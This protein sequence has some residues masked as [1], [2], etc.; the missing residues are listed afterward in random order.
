MATITASFGGR[1]KGSSSIAAYS[2]I[3]QL[4]EFLSCASGCRDSFFVDG[5]PHGLA[6]I[7]QQQ[8]Q[9]MLLRFTRTLP[10][11]RISQP[12]ASLLHSTPFRMSQQSIESM[13]NLTVSAPASQR[14]RRE[15][16][17]PIHRGMTKLDRDAF[18]A[19]VKCLAVRVDEK[20][21]GAL[22][23]NKVVQRYVGKT[24]MIVLVDTDFPSVL[25]TCSQILSMS[26]KRAIEPDPN[27]STNKLLLLDVENEGMSPASLKL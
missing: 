17:P 14:S 10:P 3:S 15:V 26:R 25:W 27:T 2:F 5:I 1:G 13:R 18:K 6:H 24:R 19:K 23:K 22:S 4:F 11:A 7:R 9:R 12:T 16:P 21:I 20:S 8:D